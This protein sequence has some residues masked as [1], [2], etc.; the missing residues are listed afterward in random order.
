MS[1]LHH[2]TVHWITGRHLDMRPHTLLSNA[3]L[4]LAM[5]GLSFYV[6]LEDEPPAQWLTLF[7]GYNTV[8]GNPARLC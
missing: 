6:L 3:V 5:H 8:K 7:A 2:Q 4:V 1:R